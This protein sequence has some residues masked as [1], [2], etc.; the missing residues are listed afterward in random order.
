MNLGL[1]QDNVYLQKEG[2][3]EVNKWVIEKSK[4]INVGHKGDKH[5][6]KDLARLVECVDGI[7]KRVKDPYEIATKLLMS[8]IQK[9]PFE[10]ANRRT[11]YFVAAGYLFSHGINIKV[12]LF[13]RGTAKALIGIREDNYYTFEEVKNWLITGKIREYKRN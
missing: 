13:K 7:P 12:E 4:E 9:H 10:S 1:E 2:L 8:I 11:A 5:K 6:L 3:I